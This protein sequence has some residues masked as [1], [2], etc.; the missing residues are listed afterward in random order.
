MEKPKLSI[1]ARA[2]DATP[3]GLSRLL[4]MELVGLG[5]VLVVDEARVTWTS[6][7]SSSLMDTSPSSAASDMLCW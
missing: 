7:S 3:C 2:R 4:K 5:R 6:I 1:V